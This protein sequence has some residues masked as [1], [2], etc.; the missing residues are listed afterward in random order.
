M[1]KTGDEVG[2]MVDLNYP[3]VNGSPSIYFVATRTFK[4][5]H[6]TTPPRELVPDEHSIRETRP[7]ETDTS[8]CP[9]VHD[10]LGIALVSVLVV[11]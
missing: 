11:E 2:D 8:S 5:S 3:T 4:E 6:A 7:R 1:I 10:R 9:S